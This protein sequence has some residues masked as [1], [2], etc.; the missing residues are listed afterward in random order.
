MRVLGSREPWSFLTSF[1]NRDEIASAFIVTGAN[2]A[3]QDL[4]FEQLGERLQR[5]TD[6]AFVR[7]RSGEAPNLK[8]TLKKI[9]REATKTIEGQADDDLE[10]SIG[11]DVCSIHPVFR[12]EC[13]DAGQG[14]RYLD[15]DFE[16]LHQYVKA[17]HCPQV[18]VAFQDSEGFDSGLLSD[19]VELF[20]YGLPSSNHA[21]RSADISAG[22]GAIESHLRSFLA[23]L[24]LLTSSRPGCSSLCAN[25]CTGSSSTWHCRAPSWQRSLRRPLRH[26]MRRSGLGRCS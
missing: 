25:T 21:I 6:G 17:Y 1:R 16:A 15:Y 2:I 7:I 3:S 11:K 26:P 18:F 13:A 12:R 22:P 14:R 9:I 5:E 19:I 8:A 23:S 24:P 20:K 4:L 10:V